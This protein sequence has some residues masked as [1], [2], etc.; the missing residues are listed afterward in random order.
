LAAKAD[1]DWEKVQKA[2]RLDQYYVPTRYP[3]GL[4]GGVP[5]RFYTDPEEA[6]E[7]GELSRAVLEMAEGKLRER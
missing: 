4:P 3:N 1:S 5:S 6:R 7:A 2:A